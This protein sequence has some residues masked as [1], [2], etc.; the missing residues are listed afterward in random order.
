VLVEPPSFFILTIASL[1][2]M[3]YSFYAYCLKTKAPQEEA[4]VRI[5]GVWVLFTIFLYAVLAVVLILLSLLDDSDEVY[6]RCFGRYDEIEHNRTVET[7]RIAYHSLL[8]ALA[9]IASLSLFA[10]ESEI[11]K[12]VKSSS[13][14][15]LSYISCTSVLA[16]STLWVVYSANSGSTPYFVIPLWICECPPLL[17]A[18]FYTQPSDAQEEGGSTR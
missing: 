1:F 2:V 15:M 9:L 8:L 10:L 5:W 14:S 17:A 6:V 4:F 18:A 3:S 13:L 11:Q 7:I 12:T 16:T